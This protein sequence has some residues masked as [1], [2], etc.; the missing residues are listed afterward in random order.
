MEQVDAYENEVMEY[1]D[2]IA[3]GRKC[4]EL[5]SLAEAEPLDVNPATNTSA[6][7]EDDEDD[8]N[9]LN[10]LDDNMSD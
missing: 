5:V 1:E 6:A 2:G 7:T 10:F 8:D 9:D 3:E 4:M